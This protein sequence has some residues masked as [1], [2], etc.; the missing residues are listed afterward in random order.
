MKKTE[1]LPLQQKK[2]VIQGRFTRL[3][4]KNLIGW[5]SIRPLK[6]KKQAVP[7]ISVQMNDLRT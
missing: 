6:R 3:L 1:I 2:N 7:K 4:K 5:L